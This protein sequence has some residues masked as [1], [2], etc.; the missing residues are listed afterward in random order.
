MASDPGRMLAAAS[1]VP[2]ALLSIMIFFEEEYQRHVKLTKDSE[3]D[4]AKAQKGELEHTPLFSSHIVRHLNDAPYYTQYGVLGNQQTHY[5]DGNIVQNSGRGCKNVIY[6]NHREP[7]S[8]FI[9]GSQG[10]GKSYTLAT[11]LEN[12]LLSGSSFDSGMNPS[13]TP[14]IAFCWDTQ[15]SEAVTQYC[16]LVHFASA[17]VDVRI[18]VAPSRYHQMKKF[19]KTIPGL[20]DKLKI[21]P[22]KLL[23]KH[24]KMDN[25][26]AMMNVKERDA[27]PLYL[28]VVWNIL[29]EMAEDDPLR[30][31]IDYEAFIKK[32]DACNLNE[33][34]TQMLWLRL[35]LL[36][37]CLEIEP[38][39]KIISERMRAKEPGQHEP[40]KPYQ[41][42]GDILVE[43]L[44]SF[45]PGTLTV[46]DLSSDTVTK[47]A[48]CALFNV[49]TNL[50]MADRGKGGRVI[51]MDEAHKVRL[52]V[53]RC[54]TLTLDIVFEAEG[55]WRSRQA[56]RHPNVY[57][58]TATPSRHSGDSGDA[59][60]GAGS[61]TS[62]SLQ[63]H[64]CSSIQL[65][66]MV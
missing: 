66:K 33:A 63:C 22:L 16:E 9:C 48:A 45:K 20:K 46:V 49:C 65:Q 55:L 24:L 58:S 29:A 13:P 31:G 25:M 60:S 1:P 36:E 47:D 23:E 35:K 41:R 34:Q 7:W 56:Y 4:E 39:K 61:K 19:Y 11:L 32:L 62:G 6:G 12:C 37:D 26:M 64:H 50:F 38:R 30:E 3:E 27:T 21:T 40:I 52:P 2:L 14:V 17:G 28:A 53:S 43:D 10:G 57:H 54:S 59:G 51:A 44:W 8:A 5:R 18:V 15:S 42:K